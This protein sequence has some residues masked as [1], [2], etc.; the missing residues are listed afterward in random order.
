MVNRENRMVGINKTLYASVYSTVSG[1]VQK[2][3]K[4]M[5]RR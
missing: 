1:L 5:N 3:G 2:I 4:E